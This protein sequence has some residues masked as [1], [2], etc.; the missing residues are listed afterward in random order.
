MSIRYTPR[1]LRILLREVNAGTE[2]S[3]LEK[4]LEGRTETG[5]LYK[6]GR[7]AREDPLTWVH[8]KVTKYRKRYGNIKWQSERKN[9]DKVES[10]RRKVLD[11]LRE[12]PDAVHR[13]LQEARLGYY[14]FLAFGNNLNLARRELNLPERNIGVPTK[15]NIDDLKFRIIS[16]LKQHPA[17]TYK[18]VGAAGYGTYRYHGLSLEYLRKKAKIPRPGYISGAAAA[19]KLGLSREGISYLHRVGKLRG[20]RVGRKIYIS[21]REVTR[22]IATSKQN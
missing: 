16:Y 17:A 19:R 7:L 8:D 14:L 10:S 20:Y 5:I 21:S 4:K 9:P 1:E 3:I 22:R 15:F 12:H 18:D 2:P 13:D 11:Y 6:I